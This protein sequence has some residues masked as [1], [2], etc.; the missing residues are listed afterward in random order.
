MNSDTHENLLQ[1]KAAY[2]FEFRNWNLQ[3]T[4]VENKPTHSY[5]IIVL[6]DYFSFLSIPFRQCSVEESFWD[7]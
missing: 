6:T 5:Q 1:L 2:L 3:I 4:L 7:Q